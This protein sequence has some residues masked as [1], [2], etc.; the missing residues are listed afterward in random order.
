ML[1]R[2][3]AV[4]GSGSSLR[5]RAKPIVFIVDDDV[6]VRE[7]LASLICGAG[8]QSE[9]FASGKEFLSRPRARGPGCLLLDVSMPDLNGLDLQARIA[10]ER[11]H[12]PIIFITGHGDVPTTV[13]AM[14][15]GAVEFFTKP[16]RSDSLLR[17]IQDA[18]DR[19]HIVLQEAARLD[20]LKGRYQSLSGREREVMALVVRGSLN[21]QV[22]GAMGITEITVKVHRSRVMHKMKASSL[23]HLVTMA[24]VLGVPT[25]F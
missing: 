6:D 11:T 2:S 25:A 7:S 21:K 18:I 22:A 24:G 4:R 10:L 1:S 17:A 5:P 3:A 13:K 12:V 14:K 8:W 20:E 15:A 9:S 23:A 16:F 19:S